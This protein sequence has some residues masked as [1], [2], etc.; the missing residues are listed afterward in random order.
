VSGVCHVGKIDWGAFASNFVWAL[1]SKKDKWSMGETIVQTRTR[2]LHVEAS[3]SSGQRQ[4]LDLT[5]F[6]RRGS[7]TTM[8]DDRPRSN[9]PR[10]TV[11]TMSLTEVDLGRAPGLTSLLVDPCRNQCRHT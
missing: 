1:L 7:G 3:R 6:R 10:L 11:L 2:L 5:D 8:Q 9:S 4:L